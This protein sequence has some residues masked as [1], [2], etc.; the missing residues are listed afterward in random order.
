MDNCVLWPDRDVPASGPDRKEL[1]ELIGE[2]SVVCNAMWNWLAAEAD[3]NPGKNW[4][5]ALMFLQ[6]IYTRELGA[7]VPASCSPESQEWLMGKVGNATRLAIIAKTADYQA[8]A[9]SAF[10]GKEKS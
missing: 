9:A 6:A 8:R 7:P 4:V 2:Y 5:S 1:V 10:Q 3:K